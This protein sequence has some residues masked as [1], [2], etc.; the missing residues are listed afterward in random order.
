MSRVVSLSIIPETVSFGNSHV[1]FDS[2][3]LSA[4]SRE[5]FLPAKLAEQNL[6]TGQ[7]VGRGTTVFFR[8]HGQHWVLRHYCRGG[9]PARVLNDCYFGFNLEK[10]RP[11]KEW[12]LLYD[13]YTR[14]FPVP[15]PVAALTEMG[16]GYYRGDLIT[17]QIPATKTLADAIKM[18]QLSSQIWFSIGSCLR[19]F[20]NA[21]VFHADLNAQNI[22]L[23][24]EENVFLIDFDRSSIL[25]SQRWK[26]ASLRRLHRSL[27]KVCKNFPCSYFNSK[28][29]AELLAGYEFSSGS[30]RL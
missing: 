9:L 27:I 8:Y 24:E 14:G 5:L 21:G 30:S 19:L 26:N 29:W 25:S 6:V 23:D 17:E 22:L 12:W 4:P 10:G 3:L 11:W 16:L 2:S 20:H 13:L 18:G 15:R 28:D 1:L 7:A